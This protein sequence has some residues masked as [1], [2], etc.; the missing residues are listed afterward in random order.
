MLDLLAAFDPNRVVR[1]QDHDRV[2]ISGEKRSDI[3]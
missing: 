1:A 2:A 3:P